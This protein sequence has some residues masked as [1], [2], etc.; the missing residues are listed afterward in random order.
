MRQMNTPLRDAGLSWQ[1]FHQVSVSEL[2]LPPAVLSRVLQ[3]GCVLGV[4]AL[5]LQPEE[6]LDAEQHTSGN[7]SMA[8][9]AR[10]KTLC[11]QE[12][13]RKVRCWTTEV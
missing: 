12:S 7:V 4:C 9:L 13:L 1:L 8:H 5:G 2:S 11:G 6:G 10:L 3:V